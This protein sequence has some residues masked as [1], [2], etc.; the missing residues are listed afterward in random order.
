MALETTVLVRL[1]L[2]IA[3]QAV[4]GLRAAAMKAFRPIMLCSPSLA[5]IAYA[6]TVEYVT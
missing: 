4:G 3:M 2:A 1:M 6:M 5:S